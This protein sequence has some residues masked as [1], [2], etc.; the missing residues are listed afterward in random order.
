MDCPDC[1]NIILTVDEISQNIEKFTD[2][3]IQHEVKFDYEN[4]SEHI[5]EWSRHT[6]RATRRDAEKFIISQMSRDEAFCKF[7]WGQKI[8]PQ[9]YSEAQ[10]TY[11]GKRGRSVLVGSFIWKDPLPLLATTTTTIT[12]FSPTIFSTESYFLAFTNAAQTELDSL[13]AG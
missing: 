2:K 10:S 6:L 9:E 11:F 4:A 13:S 3:D 8:V 5:V 7:D 1:I 12:T